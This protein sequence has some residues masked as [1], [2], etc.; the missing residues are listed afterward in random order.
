MKT[1]LMIGGNEFPPQPSDRFGTFSEKRAVATEIIKEKPDS[2]DVT[3][4]Y[5]MSRTRE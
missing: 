5:S 2:M 3:H 1:S 4:N